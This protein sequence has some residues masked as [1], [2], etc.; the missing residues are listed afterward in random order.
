MALALLQTL[1]MTAST[2]GNDYPAP[3][4]GS[5]NTTYPGNYTE[6][7]TPF[8]PGGGISYSSI[9]NT[10]DGLVRRTYN[11]VWSNGGNDNPVLFNQQPVET[12][13]ADVYVSFG[14][15]SNPNEYYAMEWKGYVAAPATTYYNF[16]LESDDVAMFWIGTA[17]LNPDSNSPLCH[18]YNNTSLNANSVLLTGELFYPIRIRFQEHTGDDCCQLYMS[19]T[20]GPLYSMN[21]SYLVHDNVNGGYIL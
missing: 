8:D 15:Q 2:Q 11:G 19:Q 18:S 21:N 9:T 16:L 10:W 4:S 14:A 17:A 13:E 20:G 3:H 7:G 6:Q 12:I 1:V 5:Y